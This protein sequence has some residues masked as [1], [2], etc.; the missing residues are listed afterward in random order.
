[1]KLTNLMSELVKRNGSDLHLTGDCLPYFRIQGQMV[2][3]SSELYEQQNLRDELT[4]ILGAQ[5][6]SV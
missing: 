3:A 2:P 4:A 1:M 6:L 5:K